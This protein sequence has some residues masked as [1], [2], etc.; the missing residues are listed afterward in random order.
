M[1][2]DI[3]NHVMPQAYL[4]LV[5]KHSKEPG[6]VKRMSNLRMLWDIEH[7]V[8]M[9]RTK[10]P[11][12][13]QVL[14]LSLP[15]P[16][17]LGGPAESHE[18]ARVAN[19]GMAEMCR[20]WPEEFP[21]FV[22]S[23]P[24]NNVDAAL[25]EMDRAI[26]KL[27]AKG[28]QIISSVAGRPL[29]DPE[30]FPVFERITNHHDRAIWM[31]PARPASRAD[32]AGEPKS[33][34]EIWQVLGWPFETSVAMA[35]IVFS[36]LLQRL[37]KMRIITHHCGGMIPYFAGRAETL[38]AQLGSR[39][40]DA[41]ESEVLKRLAKPPIEYFKMFY[42]DTVLG[43]A[44]APLA[45][46]V[47]FFGA[48]RVVFASDCPFDPEG[49]PMFIREGIRSIEDLKLP[50]GDKRKIYFGNALKLLRMEE[51]KK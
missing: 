26:D 24:M 34:Y 16:E 38:W 25:K 17:L 13:K 5:K 30:F 51:Q 1:K 44:T 18:F 19:D 20:R 47:A 39:S 37:P 27:G 3:F 9:L 33:K 11:D 15:A 23:L 36:G 32:Y 12:V 28:I 40:T 10:F 4:E 45:C 29:D 46:G 48:D 35:R 50:E 7:R 8:E 43:G 41:E 6:L 31:H 49:G 21:A 42:G 2:I 22:A 14:T